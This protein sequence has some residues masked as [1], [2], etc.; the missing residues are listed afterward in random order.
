[1]AKYQQDDLYHLNSIS[2]YVLAILLV[3]WIRFTMLGSIIAVSSVSCHS[4]NSIRWLLHKVCKCQI[5][6]TGVGLANGVTI[7]MISFS[8]FADLRHLHAIDPGYFS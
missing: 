1:M 4:P 2:V 7:Q 3:L 5:H 8:D 6:G